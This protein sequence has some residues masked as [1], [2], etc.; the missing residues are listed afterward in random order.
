[1]NLPP[2][3]S[4]VKSSSVLSPLRIDSFLGRSLVS[5][6]LDLDR[7]HPDFR[8]GTQRRYSEIHT[9]HIHFRMARLGTDHE[10]SVAGRCL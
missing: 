5:F 6:Q 7:V 8:L 10:Q 1:M 3:C 4:S 9:I 2:Q